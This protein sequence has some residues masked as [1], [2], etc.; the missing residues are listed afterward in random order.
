MLKSLLQNGI[1]GW[2]PHPQVPYP[3]IPGWLNAASAEPVDT[4]GHLCLLCLPQIGF[5]VTLIILYATFIFSLACFFLSI[6]YKDPP[7]ILKQAF[8]LPPL[9]L[10]PFL[11]HPLNFFL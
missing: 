8:P 4:E 9:L 1:A 7:G 3:R 2:P 5:R 10:L 11:F 6:I